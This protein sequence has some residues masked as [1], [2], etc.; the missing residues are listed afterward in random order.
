M[1]RSRAREQRQLPRTCALC[2]REF[3][4]VRDDAKTCGP[5]CRQAWSRT[6][7]AVRALTAKPRTDVFSCCG[8][9]RE[10]GVIYCRACGQCEGLN[11][12]QLPDQVVSNGPNR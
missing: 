11:F 1:A 2:S 9:K 4:A 12:G 10:P 6:M 7:R 3:L 5:K 8:R